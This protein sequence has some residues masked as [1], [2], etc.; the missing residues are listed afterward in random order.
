MG[1]R[2]LNDL[3]AMSD[4]VVVT[5]A[6]T[7][8]TRGMINEDAFKHS[9]PG[10]V[11]INIARGPIVV[12]SALV[13][14]LTTGQIAGAALDV[15]DKEPL[16]PSSI[17]YKIPNILLSPHNADQLVDSRH[18]SVKFFTENCQRFLNNEKLESVVSLV[19][20]Y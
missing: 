19:R 16:P 7:N 4:F 9:K 2:Q 8:E 17:L 11:I 12:E 1:Q 13:K 5:A 15:F 6:L 3:M 18:R 20:G 14:A 10:Q